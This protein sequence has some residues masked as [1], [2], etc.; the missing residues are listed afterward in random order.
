M[1]KEINECAI[2]WGERLGRVLIIQCWHEGLG[3][4][5]PVVIVYA[6]VSSSTRAEPCSL[7]QGSCMWRSYSRLPQTRVYIKTFP[8]PRR[9]LCPSRSRGRMWGSARREENSHLVFWRRL[10]VPSYV[11]RIA[12]RFGPRRSWDI[13]SMISCTP[14]VPTHK[15]T[16]CLNLASFPPNLQKID[17]LI[18]APAV[19]ANYFCHHLKTTRSY[20]P[21]ILWIN[22][23]PTQPWHLSS[24][25][26][27]WIFRAI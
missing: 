19:H 23:Y 10:C 18:I 8:S 12:D 1:W 21:E 2:V 11:R 16:A 27:I 17:K 9:L 7:G 25:A 14:R 24:S 4:R 22:I 3:T 20:R 5:E 26:L 6:F 15:F 13:Q